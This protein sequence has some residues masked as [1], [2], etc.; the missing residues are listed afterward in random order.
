MLSWL[1]KTSALRALSNAHHLFSFLSFALIAL[2]SQ[3]KRQC[4]L[5]ISECLLC[6]GR[7]K[8]TTVAVKVVETHVGPEQQ[9]DLRNE[10]LLSW[11]GSSYRHRLLSIKHI[12]P[13]IPPTFLSAACSL[14]LSHPNV[15]QGYNMCAVKILTDP[16]DEDRPSMLNGSVNDSVHPNGDSHKSNTYSNSGSGGRVVPHLT[17]PNCMV[18][19]MPTDAVLLPGRGFGTCAGLV[20]A[21]V[22]TA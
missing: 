8:G 6:P 17:N 4:M 1:G 3:E 11:A 2:A 12:C 5:L 7:W 16:P 21:G 19:V 13:Y 14:S 22:A 18:E 10:P 20:I 15:L 9:Y